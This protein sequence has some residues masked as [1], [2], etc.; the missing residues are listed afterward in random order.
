MGKDL[1]ENGF[2]DGYKREYVC[3]AKYLIFE[4]GVSE[5]DCEKF[6]YEKSQRKN[7][8]TDKK[9][10]DSIDDAKKYGALIAE[11][12]VNINSN[13][14]ECLK[15]IDD[16]KL[17]KLLFVIISLSKLDKKGYCNYTPKEINQ[18]AKTRLARDK[19]N[20]ELNKLKFTFPNIT[21]YTSKSGA[22]SWNINNLPTMVENPKHEF[23]VYIFDIMKSFPNFCKNCKSVFHKEKKSRKELCDTCLRESDLEKKRRWWNLH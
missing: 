20:Y 3:L 6:L 18:I 19:I 13:D 11:T 16:A 4:M 2:K 15:L 5:N 21:P 12:F 14:L 10:K 22:T 8:Y 9:I 1:Y 7:L 23:S 17:R